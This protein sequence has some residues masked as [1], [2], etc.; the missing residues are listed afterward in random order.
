VDGAFV[1][2]I[3]SEME[4][5]QVYNILSAA[6][7]PRPIA[8]VSTVGSDGIANLAP[9][10]FFMLGGSN[11]PSLMISPTL[12]RNLSEKDTLA[13]I[14]ETGE[15][16][17]NTVHRE[18]VDGMNRT[19]AALPRNEDE[20]EVS[21]FNRLPSS[22]VS[23][24]RVAESLVSLECKLFQVVDHGQFAGSARYIIGE[25]VAI[26]I[27]SQAFANG[28]IISENLRLVSR[29]GGPDYLDTATLDYFQLPRP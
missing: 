7:Q 28:A 1:S 17:V 2:M 6:V 27:Q 19:S 4:P 15:F 13:N 24:S 22:I 11:P 23:P 25:I 8:F 20:W 29:M 26:H 16:V 18:M 10:S 21:G 9:F 14:R 12:N 3:P 5:L